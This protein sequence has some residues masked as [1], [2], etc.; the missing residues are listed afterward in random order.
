[1]ENEITAHRDGVVRGLA[2]AVGQPVANG[3]VVCVIDA[4]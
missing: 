3:Q 4:T 1:M 2:V